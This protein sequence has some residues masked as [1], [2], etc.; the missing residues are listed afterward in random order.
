M[1]FR[2]KDLRDIV[3]IVDRARPYEPDDSA[4]I[5]FEESYGNKIIKIVWD[6]PP[7]SLCLIKGELTDGWQPFN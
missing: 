4:T 5:A 1:A 7:K 2:L 3:N 6:D